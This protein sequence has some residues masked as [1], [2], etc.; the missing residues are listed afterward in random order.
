MS[1][2]GKESREV[3]EGAFCE[4]EDAAVSEGAP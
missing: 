4:E 2:Y 1:A 3:R